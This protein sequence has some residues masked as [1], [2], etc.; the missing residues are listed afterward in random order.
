MGI[1]K[2]TVWGVQADAW[3]LA[4]LPTPQLPCYPKI[5]GQRINDAINL[6]NAYTDICCLTPRRGV[7]APEP[8]AVPVASVSQLLITVTVLIFIDGAGK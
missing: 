6:A 4:V 8:T 3:L 1:H 5:S 2:Q 7:G